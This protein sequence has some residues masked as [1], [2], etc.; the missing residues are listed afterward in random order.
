MRDKILYESMLRRFDYMN[1]NLVKKKFIEFYSK[2]AFGDSQEGG[3]SGG[4]A[5]SPA[6]LRLN[7]Y[8]K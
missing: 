1:Y 7:K 3:N 5:P 2:K 8:K 6:K 4:E